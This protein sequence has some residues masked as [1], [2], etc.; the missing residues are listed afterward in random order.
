[1]KSLLLY[2]LSDTQRVVATLE[3]NDILFTKQWRKSEVE[4]WRVGKGVRVPNNHVIK[5]G[6]ILSSNDEVERDSYLS[7][8]ETSGEYINEERNN[9]ENTHNK[10]KTHTHH[11]YR[12]NSRDFY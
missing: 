9:Y 4:P 6:K 11:K 2:N 12:K 5:L 3:P 7:E 8:Y 1:M 10:Y